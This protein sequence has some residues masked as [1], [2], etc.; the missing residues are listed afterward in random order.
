[1]VGRFRLSQGLKGESIPLLARIISIIDAYDVMLSGR[2][3]KHPVSSEEA[4]EE[5][6]TC[7]GKQFDPNLVD[8]F[9]SFLGLKK[10]ISI[11]C[12]KGICHTEKQD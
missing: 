2:P 9:V 6:R 5:L 4:V 1:M 3:Y 12:S 7:A 8:S 10:Q 11:S